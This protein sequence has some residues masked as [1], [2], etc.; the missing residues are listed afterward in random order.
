MPER[1]TLNNEYYVE[2]ATK[3]PPSFLSIKIANISK[4]KFRWL[5]IIQEKLREIYEEYCDDQK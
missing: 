5:P 2:F 3:E 4:K 1:A